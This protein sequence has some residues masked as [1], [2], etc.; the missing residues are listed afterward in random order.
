MTSRFTAESLA[1]SGPI[2]LSRRKFGDARG[3]LS[4]L[5]C[6]EELLEHGWPGPVLQ[7]NETA[8]T[9]KATVRGMH[10]QRP[11]FGEWKLVT[12]VEGAIFDVAVDLRQGSPSFL[13][14]VG[15]ELSAQNACSLLIPAGFAHGFQSLTDHVRMIYVHSAP[16]RAEAEGGLFPQDPRLDIAWPLPVGLMSERDRAHPP[17]TA[18]FEG[19]TP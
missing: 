8:T 11:P 13:R 12:C 6:G 4:R 5:F 7:V 18:D 14:H 17:L 19:L 3:H 1:I 16:Y 10:F 9:G 2:L 15:V